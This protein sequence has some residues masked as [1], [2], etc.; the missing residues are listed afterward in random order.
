MAQTDDVDGLVAAWPCLLFELWIPLGGRYDIVCVWGKPLPYGKPLLL[1]QTAVS[2][3][4][5][6][7]LEAPVVSMDRCYYG[8]GADED[9]TRVEMG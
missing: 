2:C 8:R 1:L 9:V 6:V 4:G 7:L 5:V 3:E